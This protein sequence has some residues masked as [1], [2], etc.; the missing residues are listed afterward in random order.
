MRRMFIL[1][2]LLL[3]LTCLKIHSGQT[4][5]VTDF[6]GNNVHV[7]DID[8]ETITNN[9]PVGKQPIGMAISPDGTLAYVVNFT[10]NSVSVINISENKVIETITENISLT[11]FSVTFAPN[12]EKAYIGNS[13]NSNIS[14]I[15]TKSNRAQLFPTKA[16]APF[17]AVSS[18]SKTFYLLNVTDSQLESYDSA[19][20]KLKN[21]IPVG[22]TPTFIVLAPNGC[23]VY[24]TITV[25]F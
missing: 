16:T 2:I 4:A 21:S 20:L 23:I 11:P 5:Y 7:I 19:T 8:T 14:I 9:I 13:N 12:G 25:T 22:L 17:I 10:D 3:S 18:D 6:L 24:V 1:V 15:D